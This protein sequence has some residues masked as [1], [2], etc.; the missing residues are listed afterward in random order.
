MTEKIDAPNPLVNLVKRTH[1]FLQ[2]PSVYAIPGCSCGNED[3]QWSEYQAHLWCD[4]CAIDFIPEHNGVFDGPIMM[5][6]AQ[7]MGMSFSRLDLTTHVYEVID[8]DSEYA[9]CHHLKDIFASGT[10]PLYFKG[11]NQ[12]HQIVATADMSVVDFKLQNLQLI[13]KNFNV[14]K[15]QV[16]FD[17]QNKAS[18]SLVLGKTDNGFE[19]VPDAEMNKLEQ[20]ILKGRLDYELEM[21]NKGPVIKL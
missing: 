16:F 10:I 20:Y 18:F 2:S 19:I 17:I 8:S 12:E 5:N 6:L 11:L 14:A 4:K 7:S 15:T 1:V 9:P 3:T 21:K 13:D